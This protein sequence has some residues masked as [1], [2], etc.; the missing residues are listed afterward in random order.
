MIS[1]NAETLTFDLAKIL[2]KSKANASQ[3]A[4][5]IALELESRV[6]LKSPVDTGRLRGNWN[7][8]INSVNTTEYPEDRSGGQA[9]T[10]ALGALSKFKVGDT[11]WITNNLPYVAK[12]E[13]GLYGNGAK[14]VG[15]YSKQAPQGFIRITYL[16]VMGAFE[17]IGN[18]VVK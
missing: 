12:L 13:Y 16:E 14:T 3:V 10:R 8:G 7:V 9:D 2:E 4:R 6:V 15:G 1:A 17:N 18:K 11:I 5:A